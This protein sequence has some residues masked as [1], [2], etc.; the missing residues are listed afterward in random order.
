M[1]CGQFGQDRIALETTPALRAAEGAIGEQGDAVPDAAGDNPAQHAG[2]VPQ[3]QLDLYRGDLGD[4]AR[5]LDLS[6]GDIAQPDGFDQAAPRQR[7]Q[8]AD[9]GGQRYARIR[10][11]KLIQRYPVETQSPQ[12]RLTR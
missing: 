12:A 10:R 5:F 1:I 6:D 4:A 3:A 7:V 9:A 8:G 2:V 11:V